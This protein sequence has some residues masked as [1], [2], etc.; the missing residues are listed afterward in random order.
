MLEARIQ[1]AQ[2]DLRKAKNTLQDLRRPMEQRIAEMEERRD[3]LRVRISNMHNAPIRVQNL[4]KE[5]QELHAKICRLKGELVTVGMADRE[6][7]MS[8]KISEEDLEFW[9][10]FALKSGIVLDDDELGVD[11]QEAISVMQ[12]RISSLECVLYT[13]EN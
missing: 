13:K 3:L 6:P 8:A 10:W 2:Q 4:E 9:K 7:M 1:K 5:R 11:K 12:V